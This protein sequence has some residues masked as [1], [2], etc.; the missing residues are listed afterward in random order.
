MTRTRKLTLVAVALASLGL[1][2]T[3]A[4][5][6]SWWQFNHPRRAEVNERLAFQNYRINR[7][8]REG[9]LSPWQARRLHFRD[10]MIRREERAMARFHYGHITP[11][12]QHMLNHQEN[13][14]GRRI[15]Y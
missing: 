1:S 15:G 9:E 4:S 7:E 14:V 12:E 3:A 6:E 2:A 11:Y 5:A 8:L 10:F 13:F